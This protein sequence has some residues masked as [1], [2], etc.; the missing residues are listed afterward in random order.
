MGLKDAIRRAQEERDGKAPPPGIVPPRPATGAPLAAPAA[1]AP[2]APADLDETEIGKILDRIEEIPT[3]PVIATKVMDTINHPLSDAK[4]I[5]DIIRNDQALSAK[6]LRMSN[7]AFYK[8]LSDITSIQ[9]AV[10]RLGIMQ[11]RRMVLTLSVFDTFAASP[12]EDFSLRDFWAH[13]IAVATAARQIGDRIAAPELE[14]L[15]T[16][17]ILHDIGKVIMASHLKPSFDAV[18][19]RLKGEP[20]VSFHEAERELLRATH[21]QVGSWLA[22]KWNLSRKI[23]NVI[24]AHHEPILDTGTFTRDVLLF[25]AIVHVANHLAK[26]HGFGAAIDAPD[27]LDPAAAEF[28]FGKRGGLEAVEE[29][30]LAERPKIEAF[31]AN[32]KG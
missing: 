5:G 9:T 26:K 2:A 24:F 13:S 18:I 32:M 28:V 21:C 19:L 17:G 16:A 12:G 30:F 10:A 14:D 1:E 6:V 4:G 11:I 25:P 3:L 31:L 8:G 27:E 15:Y 22:V 7:S 29:R 20:R 23:Q